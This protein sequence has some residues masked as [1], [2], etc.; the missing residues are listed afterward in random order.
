MPKYLFDM[1][2][3]KVELTIFECPCG[4]HI[5]LDSTYIDQISD[6]EI[7]CPVCQV[8]ITTNN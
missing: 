5:G 3:E 4:F 8:L 1:F 7:N 2:N 6:I